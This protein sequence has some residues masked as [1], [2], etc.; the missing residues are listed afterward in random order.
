MDGTPGLLVCPETCASD[1]PFEECACGVNALLTGDTTW[2]NL[3]PCV[4][5][6]AENQRDF[7]AAMPE[8]MIEDM[9]RDGVT[10]EEERRGEGGAEQELMGF[11]RFL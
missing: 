6:S 8:E 10:G 3:F 4:L 5:N 11:V 1:T 7:L 2:Q 9:V